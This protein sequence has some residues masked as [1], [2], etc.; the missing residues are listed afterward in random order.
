MRIK[1]ILRMKKQIIY[2][3]DNNEFKLIGTSDNVFSNDGEI[4]AYDKFAND[5]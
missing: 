4:I 3:M 5:D 2:V 1:N